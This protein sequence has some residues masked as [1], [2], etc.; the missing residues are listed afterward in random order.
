METFSNS[1]AKD[2]Y[3]MD[4]SECPLLTL[5]IY[6]KHR[7]RCRNNNSKGERCRSGDIHVCRCGTDVSFS[8]YFL[9]SWHGTWMLFLQRMHTLHPAHCGFMKMIVARFGV[10][11][12]RRMQEGCI[13]LGPWVC[14][15]WSHE[16]VKGRAGPTPTVQGIGAGVV[17]VSGDSAND[18]P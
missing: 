5:L 15:L 1:D 3:W 14:D 8:F 13:G 17:C 9:H 4:S 2:I 12:Q 6:Y 10:N 18:Y 11:Q 16:S 7:K